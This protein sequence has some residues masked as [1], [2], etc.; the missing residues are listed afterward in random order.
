MLDGQDFPVM[1]QGLGHGNGRVAG[2][3]A[4]VDDVFR[5]G[6]L[7]SQLQ[8]PAFDPSGEHIGIGSLCQRKVFNLLEERGQGGS[9]IRCIFFGLPGND[10]HEAVYSRRTL[11]MP[12]ETLNMFLAHW[13][14]YENVPGE[15]RCKIHEKPRSTG[16]SGF[17]QNL[18]LSS[19]ITNNSNP[20]AVNFLAENPCSGVP[21][22]VRTLD[23]PA[24]LTRAP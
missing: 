23:E 15:V 11:S 1:G 7:N 16:L 14:S 8:E 2:K 4:D 20:V 18:Q 24:P 21:G 6:Q 9:M 12:A 13:I 19:Y 22:R 10:I 3:G 5:A 17:E